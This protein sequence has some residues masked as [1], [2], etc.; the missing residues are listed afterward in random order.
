MQSAV[1]GC[2]RKRQNMGLKE[3]HPE[4]SA[5]SEHSHVRSKLLPK[6]R[7]LKLISENLARLG[8]AWGRLSVG[9]LLHALGL[10]LHSCLL[11]IGYVCRTRPDIFLTPVG[12]TFQMSASGLPE[13]CTRTRDC[14]R[15]IENLAADY[16]WATTI[17]KRAFRDA[18]M[19]GAEWADRISCIRDN[20]E[21]SVST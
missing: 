4:T 7:H 20:S 11:R 13:V 2:R 5:W 17:D 8:Q 6:A 10:E 21:A 18:W 19:R 16:P 15:D 1:K 12:P 3:F 9:S 14:K